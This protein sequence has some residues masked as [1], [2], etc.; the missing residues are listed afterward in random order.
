MK[1][2]IEDAFD[3]A[4]RLCNEKTRAL[5]PNYNFIRSEAGEVYDFSG[6]TKNLSSSNKNFFLEVKNR[7]CA[8]TDFYDETCYLEAEK[9]YSLIT[10]ANG[11]DADI[12]YLNFYEDGVA[13]CYNLS[14]IKITEVKIS[15]KMLPYK[16]K[17]D[18]EIL[19]EKLVVELPYSLAKKYTYVNDFKTN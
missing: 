7:E 5:F 17:M 13:Y 2:I 3:K 14:N 6:H 9:L 10:I 19:R 18:K 4:E 15:K 12:H 8:S 1:D 16:T 11:A